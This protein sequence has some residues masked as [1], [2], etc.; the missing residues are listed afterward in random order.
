MSRFEYTKNLINYERTLYS[1]QFLD[2]TSP[3]KETTWIFHIVPE[4]K[5]Y[6]QYFISLCLAHIFL[7]NVLGQLCDATHSSRIYLQIWRANDLIKERWSKRNNEMKLIIFVNNFWST[8][9]FQVV[10][11]QSCKTLWPLS[12]E[13]IQLPQGWSVTSKIKLTFNHLVPS[14]F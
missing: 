3:K 10:S 11:E 6:F 8:S 1:Q 13:K 12:M 4:E 9:Q 5:I 2:I 14:N 7:K